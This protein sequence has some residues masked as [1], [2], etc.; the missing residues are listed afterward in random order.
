MTVREVKE[1]LFYGT[2]WQLVGAR[3]GK[4]L[5]DSY[6]KKETIEKYMDL[7]VSDTPIMADFNVRKDTIFKNKTC[8]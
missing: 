6:N 1:L 7:S 3:T 5:C 4:K 2:N 8:V